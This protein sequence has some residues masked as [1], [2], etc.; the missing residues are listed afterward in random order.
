MHN[1]HPD[2]PIMQAEFGKTQTNDQPYW[3]KNAYK[4]IKSWPGMKAA[5]YW[6]WP[7]IALATTLSCQTK[8]SRFGKKS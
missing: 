8:V 5:L 2:K 7:D 1:N 4:T 3:L 6:D